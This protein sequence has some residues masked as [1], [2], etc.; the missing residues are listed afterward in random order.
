M[1]SSSLFANKDCKTIKFWEQKERN[2][3]DDA[4]FATLLLPGKEAPM[5]KPPSLPSTL[6][7]TFD[8]HDGGAIKVRSKGNA[9]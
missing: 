7:K 9:G 8:L 1:I 5:S 2:K 6:K 4:P 3:V